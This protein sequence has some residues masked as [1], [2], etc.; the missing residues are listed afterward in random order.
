M[1]FYA[2]G[3]KEGAAKTNLRRDCFCRRGANMLCARNVQPIQRVRATGRAVKSGLRNR[4]V[5]L[6]CCLFVFCFF[7][8]WYV[9]LSFDIASTFRW[10]SHIHLQA[11]RGRAANLD[12]LVFWGVC[13]FLGLRPARTGSYGT[14]KSTPFWDSFTILT[15]SALRT[16]RNPWQKTNTS[17]LAPTESG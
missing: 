12:H 11:S 2:C 15:L 9:F 14:T 10:H 5:R 7:G 3:K 4:F 13:C 17:L 16:Q 8:C 1:T 6:L